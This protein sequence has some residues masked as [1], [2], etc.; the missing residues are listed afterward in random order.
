MNRFNE[1]S[2]KNENNLFNILVQYES[3]ENLFT[4]TIPL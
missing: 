2:L 3:T 4:V 1:I